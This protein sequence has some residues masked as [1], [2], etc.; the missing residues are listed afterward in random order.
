MNKLQ[1]CRTL[2]MGAMLIF[3]LFAVSFVSAYQIT[4]VTPATIYSKSNAGTASSLQIAILNN[5]ATA[6]N[7]GAA[8]FSD[9]SHIIVTSTLYNFGTFTANT[10]RTA[11]FAAYVNPGT[12]T[13][14]YPMHISLGSQ[15]LNFNL[16]VEL[17]ASSTTNTSISPTDSDG[18]GIID[19]L[20]NCPGVYNPSQ[21]DTDGDGIGD[22]CEGTGSTQ[23]DA[24]G[25]GIVNTQDNCPNV[26]NSNQLDSD[27]DGRGNVCDNCPNTPNPGQEDSDGDGIGNVCDVDQTGG[28]DNDNDGVADTDDNCPTVYNPSQTDT[29]GDGIGDACDPVNDLPD[30]NPNWQCNEWTACSCYGTQIRTCVDLNGCGTLDNRPIESRQC[31]AP[32][33][34]RYSYDACANDI[35]IENIALRDEHDAE[36]NPTDKVNLVVYLRSRTTVTLM[37]V[38]AKLQ[39]D[40]K[41]I[42]ADESTYPYLDINSGEARGGYFSMETKDASPGM[43]RL[44][45]N[46][47]Y[48]KGTSMCEINLPFNMSVV[49]GYGV[50][51]DLVPDSAEFQPDGTATFK[52]NVL[53]TGERSDVYD[54]TFPGG[55]SNWIQEADRMVELDAKEAQDLFV[56][57]YVPQVTGS[58]ELS[59]KA[60]SKQL[61]SISNQDT[62]YFKVT[63][64]LAKQHALELSVDRRSLDIAMGQQGEIKVSV[65]NIGGVKDAVNLKLTGPDW[66]YLAPSTMELS[67]GELKQATLYLAPDA[68]VSM[69]TTDIAIKAT[70]FGGEASASE[71]VAVF[72]ADLATIQEKAAAGSPEKSSPFSGFAIL[73][74]KGPGLTEL[75]LLQGLAIIGLMYALIKRHELA[76]R[77]HKKDQAQQPK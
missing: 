34:C 59:A 8:L 37:N 13:G 52:I 35:R 25:D 20:D 66:A 24:D 72:A 17:Q 43:Y 71:T 38:K 64:T 15:T 5:G 21:T 40:L 77:H 63:R 48:V 50:R 75:V 65:Q 56:K 18:D 11:T 27:G 73:S 61:S 7:V 1:K 30:C 12:P 62:S 54:I 47:K 3:M 55:V 42:Y 32:S 9:D 31:T 67:P 49:G 4:Q 19:S 45:M 53:N 74:G 68:D 2:R 28:T 29:D 41:P 69:G 23:D 39:E 6:Y 14:N 60:T 36:I 70:T 76:E 58:Y 22:A 26:A 51:V 44:S 33:S 10:T 16:H 57:L 46:L